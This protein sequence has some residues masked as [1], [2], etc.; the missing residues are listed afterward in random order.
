[1]AQLI[2]MRQRIKAIETIKKI[3]HAMRLISMSTHSR[4]R[5]KMPRLKDYSNEISNIFNKVRAENPDW[6]NPIVFPQG[7][8]EENRLIILIS[9]Q[10]GL[11]GTFNTNLFKEFE[12]QVS[13]EELKQTKII[14]VGKKAVDFIAKKETKFVIKNFQE[15]TIRNF[16]TI[17]QEVVEEIVISSPPYSSVRIFSNELRSFFLQLP[18]FIDLIP[19]KQETLGE[20]KAVEH[21]TSEDLIWYQNP[22]EFLDSLVPQYIGAGINAALL[23]SLFAEQ[24]A[25]FI[26]MDT[27]NRNAK[28]LLEETKLRYNKLRQAKITKELTELAGNF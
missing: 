14:A 4:I 3:T 15:L 27:A 18:R 16:N 20:E 19:L 28:T 21:K 26:S 17:A 7:I 12:K 6:T 5:S 25:R 1:M 23:E 8:T 22:K 13:E 2:Q 11:C 24:A 9:S 10:K